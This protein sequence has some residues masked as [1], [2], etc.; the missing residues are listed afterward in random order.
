MRRPLA[1]VAAVALVATASIAP[2][3]ALAHQ[4]NP[5]MKSVVRDLQP[6]VPG[7]SL[8]VLSGDDRFQIT[9]RSTTTVLVQGYEKEPYARI[10]P[11]G[12]VTVNH[13]SPAFYLNTD[14]YGAVTVPKTATARATPDWHV[15][16]K[17]GVFEW[18]DH[19]MHYMARGIP[20]IVKD[21][22]ARTKIFDYRIPIQ[23]GGKEGQILGTLW[24]APA[25]DGGP[26]TG[27]IVAFVVLVLAGLGAVLVARRRRRGADDGDDGDGDGQPPAGE[28]RPATAGSAGE[29][30]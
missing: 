5:N 30:W 10:T 23:I 19:R 14:R 25:K 13:N 22:S 2:T 6:H 29:A 24:W 18:H 15:L 16:D 1:A 27:A 8:Q 28:A 11:D 20:S 21:K 3:A 17:T 26:P 7:V 12:T 4:G 9:N